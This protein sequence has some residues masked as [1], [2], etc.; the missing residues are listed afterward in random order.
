MIVFQLVTKKF[1]KS[2]ALRNLNFSIKKNEVVGLIGNNGAGKS[3]LIHL[4][5]NLLPFNSGEIFV[6]EKKLTS[7]Y[8][9]YKSKTGFIL[10]K[11]FYIEDFSVKE[12]LKFVG[13]FQKIPSNLLVQRSQDLFKKLNFTEFEKPISKLSKGNQMKVSVIASLIHNP[14]LLLYDEPFVNLDV[15]SQEALKSLLKEMKGKKTMLITSHNL[16]LVLDVCD[17]FLVIDNGHLI[18]DKLKK[19]SVEEL[20]KEI[21][22]LLHRNKDNT[23]IDWLK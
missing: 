9:S 15:D 12:Y 21:T 23:E 6:F 3:T 1:G 7:N 10:S 22:D 2:N 5:A 17:R 19:G 13:K 8:L 14:S 11:P 20:K 18:L 16:D 4:L